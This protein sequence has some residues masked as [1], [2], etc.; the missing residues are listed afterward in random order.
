[1]ADYGHQYGNV[2]GAFIDSWGRG[3]FVI[4]IGRK[5]FRFEDSDMFGPTR[6]RPD[7]EIDERHPFFGERSPFWEA[8]YAWRKGGR[9]VAE[10]GITCVWDQLK[11]TKIYMI[12]EKNAVVIEQGDDGGAI[13]DV[14]DEMKA[15]N[16]GPTDFLDKSA[17]FKIKRR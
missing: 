17:R 9:R 2:G 14:T 4:E 5:S 15:R 6:L 12:D 11:P 8:F 13:V 1:M 3:P 7:G 10:D 16:E